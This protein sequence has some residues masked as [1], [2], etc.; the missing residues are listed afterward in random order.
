MFVRRLADKKPSVRTVAGIIEVVARGT[1]GKRMRVPL[2]EGDAW[3]TIELE[4]GYR[5]A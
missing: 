2:E 1:L 4:S 3:C 5:Q